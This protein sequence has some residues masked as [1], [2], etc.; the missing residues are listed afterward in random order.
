MANPAT[1]IHFSANSLDLS[2]RVQ[3]S[4][5]V[6]ASPSDNTETTICSL[7]VSGNLAVATGI[8]LF[9]WAA[10]TVGTSGDGVNL[11]IRQTDTS[12]S[13]K[14]ATGLATYTAAD[15]G[16]LSVH[17]FD[18]GPTL[19]GQVYVLTMTVHAGAAASTV[20]AC[21]LTAIVL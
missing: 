14:A 8:L 5:T 3:R 12:G 9:G 11:K 10:F 15:L 19:P 17:A 1:P 21:Q 4:V 13:T 2:P 18:T 20:S 6:A 16:S 7:T